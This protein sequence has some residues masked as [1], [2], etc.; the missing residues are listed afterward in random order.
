MTRKNQPRRTARP[1]ALLRRL[2]HAGWVFQSDVLEASLRRDPD[3]VETLV[4][5][6]EASTRARRYRRGLELDRVLV[7]RDPSDHVFRY[8]LA[9][10]L[11]L[12][13]DLAA[14]REALLA[15]VGLGYS[16]FRHLR[17]D[18]DLARLR[19][20]PDYERFLARLADLAR[21]VRSDEPLA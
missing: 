6:A 18:P 4:Q 5:L 19:R 12:S 14:A 15:A 2:E 9:C 13:G 10:S 7:R 11:A 3:D 16:D 8:N 1:G 17:E 21:E 20:A